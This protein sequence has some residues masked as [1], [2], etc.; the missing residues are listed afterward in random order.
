VWLDWRSAQRNAACDHSELPLPSGPERAVARDLLDMATAIYL[1]DLAVPRGRNEDFVRELELVLPVREPDFWQAQEPHLAWL[2]QRLCGDQVHLEF[3]PREGE[4]SPVESARPWIEADSVSLLSGGLDS[5][6]GAALLLRTDRRPRLIMHRSG[7]PA[8]AQAQDRLTDTLAQ[9]W[10]DQFRL[11]AVRLAPSSHRTGALPFPGPELRESTR[12]CRS[13]LYLALGAVAAAGEGVD[14]LYLYDNAVLTSAVPLSAARCGS[15]TTHSTHP[16][17]LAQFNELLR[18]AGLT[19]Q[20]QNPFLYQ[21]KGEL[22]RT[23]LQPVFSPQEILQTVSCWAVGRQQ[24]QCGGCVPC[25]L[26]RISLLAAGLPDEVYERDLLGHPY[27]YQDTD[28]HR[29]LTDL[30]GWA[31]CVLSTPELRLP[32]EY[33]SLLEVQAGGAQVM[34]VVRALRRQATEI[35]DV[36]QRHFPAAAAL[37]NDGR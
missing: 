24:R 3:H 14:E 9:K 20:V 30:L 31:A 18:A 16:A 26:R 17:V 13:L 1:A 6:A 15:F 33:P 23:C 36:V 5:A 28:G 19:V 29:N 22:I 4:D 21:A 35:F 34:E 8:V 7:N 12:R 32:L 27:H 37:M 2:L 11:S 25:L 10:P